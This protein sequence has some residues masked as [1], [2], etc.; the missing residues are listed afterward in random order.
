MLFD[1]HVAR[2]WNDGQIEHWLKADPRYRGSIAVN[3]ND[4]AAA[5]REIHRARAAHERMK[6]VLVCGEA[7]HLYGHRAYWPVYQACHE[8]GRRYIGVELV[9]DYCRIAVSRLRQQT[10]N[11]DGGAT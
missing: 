10:L 2:A 3:M 8:L 4:P 7:T 1:W 11:L 5:V 9:E 6:L